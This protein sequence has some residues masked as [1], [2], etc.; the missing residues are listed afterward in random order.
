MM[1]V[2]SEKRDPWLKR[3]IM[4][5][6]APEKRAVNGP[7]HAERTVS[8]ALGILENVRLPEH[9]NC[10]ELGCGQGA[11]ARLMVERFQARMTAT[12]FDPAQ[13]R[14][15]ESR[16]RDLGERVSFRVVDARDLPFG[17]G[18]FDVVFSFGV[19]HHIAGGWRHV[20]REVSRVLTPTGLFVFTDLYPPRW[21]IW[22]LEKLF[23]HFDQLTFGSLRQV[24]EENGL[25]ITHQ[26]W[27]R[28][29]GGFLAYGKT[30]ASNTTS[31]CG[32]VMGD[33]GRPN[34]KGSPQSG[35]R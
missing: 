19:M 11:L 13:V 33:G 34:G 18:E 27:Q 25:V 32:P 24:L 20:V 17:D 30:I 31:S 4:R 6:T 22:I 14:L 16:L 1:V 10:L 7:K 28:H 35:G 8:T 9:P 29:V 2:G 26:V 12:D 15:A 3:R 23:P 5:L 21:F